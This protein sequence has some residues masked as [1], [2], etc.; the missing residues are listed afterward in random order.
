MEGR[1]RRLLN[2]LFVVTTVDI[3]DGSSFAAGER[4]HELVK[5]CAYYS[6]ICIFKMQFGMLNVNTMGLFLVFVLNVLCLFFPFRY[7]YY[8]INFKYSLLVELRRSNLQFILLG[9]SL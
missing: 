8:S 9:I 3:L 2:R 1:V 5:V 4:M 7:L 6:Y